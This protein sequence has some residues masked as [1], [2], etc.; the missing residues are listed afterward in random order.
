MTTNELLAILIAVVALA[1]TLFRWISDL[2]LNKQ[3][4]RHRFFQ[5]LIDGFYVHNWKF[6]EHWDNKGIRPQL[7]TTTDVEKSFEDFGRRVVLLD[8]LNILWRVYLHKD[9]LLKEDIDSFSS[10]ARGWLDR[11]RDQ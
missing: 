6:I 8:H 4:S 3:E 5:Q 1:L 7:E 10:W 11:S 2:R 9:V